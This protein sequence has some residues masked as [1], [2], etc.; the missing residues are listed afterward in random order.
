MPRGSATWSMMTVVLGK[1]LTRSVTFPS[2]SWNIHT[3]YERPYF[4][5]RAKP[6]R[7]SG[8]IA[9]SFST[10]APAMPLS[11]VQDRLCRMPLT[12]GFSLSPLSV[13]STS[14]WSS[15]AYAT[16]PLQSLGNSSWTLATMATSP[17]GLS[18]SS[19]FLS[20]QPHSRYTVFTMLWPRLPQSRFRMSRESSSPMYG[21]VNGACLRLRPTKLSTAA[22]LS[23][24][25]P[26]SACLL[27]SFT[28]VMANHIWMC[29]RGIG[30][31]LG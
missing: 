6:F 27:S 5:R 12:R 16:M 11:A 2:C 26:S 20:S 30:Q 1:L 14:G 25:M 28:G 19:T 15:L 13:V 31:P 3:S 4:S 17:R 29:S 8:V 21:W 9:A 22:T 7:N 23:W 18:G 24:S 10:P